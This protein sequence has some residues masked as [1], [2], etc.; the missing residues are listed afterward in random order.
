M[1]II[2]SVLKAVTPFNNFEE[3]DIWVKQQDWYEPNETYFLGKR[4]E[5]DCYSVYV[6]KKDKSENLK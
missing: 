5:Q 1:N 4:P 3:A 6:P 2:Q